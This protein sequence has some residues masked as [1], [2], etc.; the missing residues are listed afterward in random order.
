MHKEKYNLFNLFIDKK[1]MLCI[2]IPLLISMVAAIVS[3]QIPLVLKRIIDILTDG[4]PLNNELLYL[5]VIFTIGQLILQV[6]SDFYLQKIGIII[7]NKVRAKVIK[8]ILNMRTSFFEHSLS[9]NIA[10]ILS[11][12]ASS[13]YTLVSSTIPKV[14]LSIFEVLLYGIVLINLSA[15]LT[16]VILVIIPLIF[17]IYLPLGSYIEKNYS[18]M[19]KEIGNLN[20]FGT[21][22]TRSQKYIKINNT[23]KK[24]EQ[25]GKLILSKLKYIGLKK[26]K[27]TAIISPLLGALS[28]SSIVFVVLLGFYLISLKQLTTGALVAYLTLFFQI[29]TPI[30]SIGES[31][32]EFKGLIGTTERLKLLLKSNN[33]ESLY[34]GRMIPN[35]SIQKVEFKNVNFTYPVEDNI[36]EKSFSLKDISFNAKIGENI[37]FVGP[38]G[39][40][41]TTI[42]DLLECFYSIDSGDIYMNGY[43]YDYY[44]VYSIRKNISY[45]SQSYPLINGTILENLLYGLEENIS[46]QEISL[47]AKKTNFDLVIARMP[48][49]FNT[50]IG[51]EGQL[52]SGGEKQ[53]LALTRAFLN[54][55]SLVLLDEVTSALDAENEYI[56]QESIVSLKKERII[57]TIAHRLSTIQNS[58]KIIFLQ[59]G[60]IT[61]IGTHDELL[62]N[63]KLYKK[64]IDIQFR[65]FR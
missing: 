44:N 28:L 48:Q 57:F 12:D 32:T 59:E 20:A 39:A 42:F 65:K 11:N 1:T 30:A 10:S 23:Q 64:F 7:V 17:L 9:G 21:F 62:E 63:H 2:L 13:M 43:H 8:Q 18:E 36:K 22:I 6:I 16:L 26:A 5:L 34:D 25:N 60:K 33:I 54:P 29:V 61:G 55:T 58:D 50:Y 14:V 53:R 51:E 19:Q 46:E 47:A 35:N 49:G 45:V 3:V 27:L 56:I 37:A 15:K 52:L 38:S 40:G 24:E 31:F 41:K 4:K